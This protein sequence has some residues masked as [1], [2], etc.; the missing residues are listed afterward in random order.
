MEGV[1]AAPPTH[2]PSAPVRAALE[3]RRDALNARF[4]AA[5]LGAPHLSGDE[6]LAH[7]GGPVVDLLERVAG[8]DPAACA[9]VLEEVFEVSLELFARRLLGGP[10][11]SPVVARVFAD[12]LPAGAAL[13]AREPGRLV[14][15][16]CNAALAL[17]RERAGVAE[18]WLDRMT[19]V[20][21]ACGGAAEWLGAGRVLAWRGGLAQHRGP[22][23]EA[24]AFASAGVVAALSGDDGVSP[25]ALAEARA[26]PWVNPFS[27]SRAEALVLAQRTGGHRAFGGS[28]V[29]LPRVAR[30]GGRLF[31]QAG[32]DVFA[33]H[34]DCFG[35]SLVRAVPSVGPDRDAGEGP[36][37]GRDGELR[38]GA[39]RR[40]VRWATQ[41]TSVAFDATTVAVTLGH[42]YLVYVFPREPRS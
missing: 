10:G 33:L 28:F 39:A 11:V 15:P 20:A 3:H 29:G 7:V 1:T 19:A 42:S 17:G 18:A 5:R 22:A 31:A 2:R 38:D 26:D 35:A 30:Q 4:R 12:V 32:A 6:V 21:P 34:A 40:P 9:A 27:G 24:L 36:N 14:G 13:L 41:T 23:L 8:H 16:L 25:R 37:F